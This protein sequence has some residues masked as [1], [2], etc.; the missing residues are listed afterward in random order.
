[1][2]DVQRS[3]L[4]DGPG[5]RTTV[6]FKGCPLRCLWCHNPESQRPM[7]ELLAWQSRCTGCGLCVSVCPTGARLG[8]ADQFDRSR[9]TVCGACAEV[10]LSGALA[11][12][13]RMEKVADL[14]SVIRR[15]KAF[16]LAS[17][18]GL[19]VSGGEPLQQADFLHNLLIAA[20]TEGI[21]TCVETCGQ[22]PWTSFERLLP[23]TDLFLYDWK[24]SDP[25]KHTRLTGVSNRL[26]RANLER[27]LEAGAGLILRCPLIPGINDDLP[28]L[29][30]IARLSR[31]PGVLGTEVLPWHNMG[32]GKREGL[33]LPPDLADLPNT[34]DAQKEKWRET[35]MGYGAKR[36]T[37]H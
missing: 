15:D 36:L 27:L 35:L 32:V 10:C 7:P 23:V 28:H 24:A 22:A 33:G 14:M 8:P 11:Q 21:H 17:G 34:N 1:V 19:T 31:L 9:C 26:I 37:V 12:K 20:K 13:G 2:F 30:E 4:Q 25:E 18:G 5:I 29:A 3:S 16:Y 6:F